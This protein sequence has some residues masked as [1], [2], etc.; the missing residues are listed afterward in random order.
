MIPSG[1]PAGCR[2]AFLANSSECHH[3]LRNS[4]QCRTKCRPSREQVSSIG[5]I[6]CGLCHFGPASQHGVL[7]TRCRA[8]ET[9]ES[10]VLVVAAVPKLFAAVVGHLVQWLW[11][12]CLFWLGVMLLLPGQQHGSGY[13]SKL[14]LCAWDVPAPTHVEGCIHVGPRESLKS[15]VH[16]RQPVLTCA[17]AG[18]FADLRRAAPLLLGGDNGPV[19]P[20]TMGVA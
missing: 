4:Q 16:V 12:S 5:F 11:S 8:A 17:S 2:A 20:A 1:A 3:H 15:F 13:S 18:I 19:S 6:V 7:R 14:C 10:L 9:A